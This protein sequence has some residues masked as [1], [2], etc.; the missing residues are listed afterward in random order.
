MFS[1]KKS[2]PQKVGIIG[3]GI[4][5]SRIAEVLRRAEFHV[6]VWNRSPRPVPNF[7][8]SPAG[9]AELAPIIQIFV[10]NGEDLV[11]VL[12]RM[13]PSLTDQHTVINHATVSLEA[14][15]NAARIVRRNGAAFLD[16]PFTGSKLAAEAGELVYYLSGNDLDIAPVLPCLELSS[17]KILRIGE[18]VGDATVLKI[19]TNMISATTIQVLAESL[20][21]TNA[22]GISAEKLSEALEENA[23]TSP[24]V[25][26]KL[27]TMIE[28]DYDPH[29]ALKNMFK[30]A[31]FALTLANEFGIEI[32]ALA[33]TASV[34]SNMM[35]KGHGDEDYSVLSANYK[36]G[37]TSSST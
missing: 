22:S 24:L 11:E 18:R 1:S 10:R 19:A 14:T 26:M 13:E 7:L 25:R 3:L 37:K 31:S 35:K 5:G 29:F 28:G 12:E 33:T 4:I 36:S 20:A 16:C 32:P 9:V 17:K 8:N 21:L 34:M 30:D 27:P 15:R 2:T 6:Y 23:C